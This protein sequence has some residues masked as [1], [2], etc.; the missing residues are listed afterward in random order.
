MTWQKQSVDT[1]LFP[2]MLWSRPE[3]RDQA[4]KLLIIGGNQYGFSA[5]GE[6]FTAAAQAGIGVSRVLLPNKLKPTVGKLFPEAEF[7]PSTPSGSFAKASLAEWLETAS[8]ADA[9]LIAGDVGH[10]SET[11]LL[12]ES[13]IDKY[14]GP[15]TIT[16]DAA[17]YTITNPAQILARP[18][19]LLVLSMGQLQKLA[20]HA[21]TSNAVTQA[22]GLPELTSWLEQ[23]TQ[24]SSLYIVTKHH[25]HILVAV[26]GQVSSC[27]L[28]DSET[29]AWRVATA[30]RASVWWLQHPAKPFETITTSTIAS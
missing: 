17:E 22:M 19:S 10:N 20:K 11:A 30:S 14:P 7:T 12:L 6:A 16:Q 29:D 23:F 25:Q 9:V 15:L 1:P 5:A 8:W 28:T 21:H 4:G 13:F 24:D 27:P 3:R 26:N 18:D 2:D